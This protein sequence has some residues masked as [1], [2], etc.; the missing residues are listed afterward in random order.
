MKKIFLLVSLLVASVNISVKAAEE[1]ALVL[2]TLTPAD[3]LDDY[4]A[5]LSNKSGKALFDEIQTV[6]K[7]GYSA[8]SYSDLWTAFGTTDLVPGTNEIWD[9]YST[10]TFTYQRKQCGN[11]GKECDCYNREHSIPKS[12][13]GGA[14][15]RAGADLFH[16]VPTDGK[17]NG[18]RGNQP[19]GE[20]NSASYTY[21]GSKLGTPKAI[22]ITGG[23]TIAGANGTSVNC[24]A[25][26][27]FEPIDEYKGDFARGY[28]GM[29][30]KWANGDYQK[31]TQ[32]DGSTTFSN[33]YDAA[34]KFG[35]TSYGVALLMKWHRQDPVS[36][37]EIDRNNGIQQTQGNR[38]PFID[39]PYLAEYIWGEKSGQTVNMAEL[40]G[41][42]EEDFVPGESNGWRGSVTAIPVWEQPSETAQ[43]VI[44][45]GKL[46]IIREGVTYDI[47]GRR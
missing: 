40:M 11:Y 19:F 41:S 42:F 2:Q 28:L 22:I 18:M 25:S 20:V 3:Q 4:Y 32:E 46:Y 10:C 23:A 34:N 9:M 5:Q 8:L 43:K 30:V 14:T 39:Y 16:L 35:L 44:I 6:A 36:Q 31:F 17:V 26:P 37:K 27:V 15:S 47:Y 13:F 38:N 7:V 1:E 21:D 33:G 45:N 12:W 24:S 29:L